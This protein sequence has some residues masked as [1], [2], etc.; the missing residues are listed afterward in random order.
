MEWLLERTKHHR[1]NMRENISP[2]DHFAVAKEDGRTEFIQEVT[3]YVIAKAGWSD[4]VGKK[5]E[6]D[7]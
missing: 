3:E 1:E 7:K 4:L 5:T 2:K 6:G